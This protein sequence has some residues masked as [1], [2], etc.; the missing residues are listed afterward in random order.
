MGK[1]SQEKDMKCYASRKKT[2]LSLEASRNK[3]IS[4]ARAA[5]EVQTHE[6][7]FV[8]HPRE[9]EA[10]TSNTNRGAVRAAASD[11]KID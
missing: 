2:R 8:A 4:A 6:A 1:H 5:C 9:L 10:R 3:R 7:V 11:A